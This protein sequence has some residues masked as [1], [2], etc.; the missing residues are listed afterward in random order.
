[1]SALRRQLT[2]DLG[3]YSASTETEQRRR[4]ERIADIRRKRCTWA[5]KAM[6]GVVTSDIARDRSSFGPINWSPPRV[7]SPVVT[8]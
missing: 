7:R 8:R 3:S 1:M 2:D 6:Q 5:E 4:T